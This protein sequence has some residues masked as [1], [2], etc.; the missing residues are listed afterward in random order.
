MYV[1]YVKNH[2]SWSKNFRFGQRITELVI[3]ALF[4]KLPLSAK[5]YEKKLFLKTVISW[6]LGD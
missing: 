2:F 3:N 5:M 1:R 4:S 6:E